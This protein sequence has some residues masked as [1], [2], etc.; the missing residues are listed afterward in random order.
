M[1]DFFTAFGLIFLAELAD[2]SRLIGILLTAVFTS[3]WRVFWGMT[4]AYLVLDGPA[5]WLGSALTDVFNGRWVPVSAG[6]LFIAFG[7]ASFLIDDD[8]ETVA[9]GRLE[10]AR[11]LGVFTVSFLAVALGELG[12]RTQITFAALAARS[13]GPWWI[14]GGGMAALA[15]LNL[16]TV[17]IGKTVS[18][19]LR[20]STIRK[21]GGVAFVAIGAAT[22]VGAF[23]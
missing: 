15:V 14:F 16:I 9:L 5:V 12:D 10:K 2:K 17:L 20:L 19:K 6:L 11:H 21:A 8:A 13:T 7:F 1:G 22:V 3:R 23:L 18:E 4:L